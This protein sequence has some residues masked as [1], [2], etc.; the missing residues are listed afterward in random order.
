VAKLIEDIKELVKKTPLI[1]PY[2][3]YRRNRNYNEWIQKGCP[4]P[5]PH[6]VKQK[7]I[8]EYAEKYNLSVFV[9][10]GTYLGDMVNAMKKS[11]D[12][13]YSIELSEKL[14]DDAK[15]RF[16]KQKHITI[17]Q[18]DSGK[19]FKELL[20]KIQSPCLFWL[21]GH[22]SEG[23]TAKGD[24]ETPIMEELSHVSKHPLAHKHLILIDDARCF[25]GEHDYPTIEQVKEFVAERGFDEFEL[26]HDI[27]R[28]RASKG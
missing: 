28:V 7:T 22:Y 8:K 16:E 2:E 13:I 14:A 9:E 6:I 27:I 4:S 18:G 20:P 25:N 26:K 24:L 5:P 23:F 19:V 17:L 21:D 11:F 1:K 10:T 3:V 12:K 15:K